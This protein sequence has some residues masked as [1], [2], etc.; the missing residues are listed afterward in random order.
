[1]LGAFGKVRLARENR[2]GGTASSTPDRKRKGTEGARE[3]NREELVAVKILS[4]Q[5]LIEAKQ[6]DHVFNEMTLTAQLDH[7]FIVRHKILTFETPT[8]CWKRKK[9]S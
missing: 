7:P 4:K 6:V 3:E 5:M 1:M 9:I 8:K 2:D